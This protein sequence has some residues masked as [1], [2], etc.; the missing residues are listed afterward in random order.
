M[1]DEVITS[2]EGTGTE[3]QNSTSGN[4]TQAGTST[5]ATPTTVVETIPAKTERVYTQTELNAI[6]SKAKKD[7][8]KVIEDAAAAK[9]MTE[10]QKE[11]KRADDLQAELVRT[12]SQSKR[13]AILHKARDEAEKMGVSFVSSGLEDAYALGAF[14][15]IE[16]DE[17]GDPQGVDKALGALQK[18]KDYLFKKAA[19][20]VPDLNSQNRGAGDGAMTPEQVEDLKRRGRIS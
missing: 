2:Q 4:G 10:A 7:E 18:S 8:R 20:Q 5:E 15:G 16:L 11:K 3:A 17:Q 13:L 9:D 6:L 12:Q 1:P 19:V 14:G